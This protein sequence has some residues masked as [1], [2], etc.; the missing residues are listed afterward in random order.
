MT[1]GNPTAQR[2]DTQEQN[3]A[4]NPRSPRQIKAALAFLLAIYV[5]SVLCLQAFGFIFTTIGE[6][7]HAPA[8]GQLITAIPSLVLGI[9]CFVYGSLADY[10][11]LR[12]MTVA[13]IALLLAGSILGFALHSNIWLVIVARTLQTAGGQVAGS[14]YLVVAAKY[15]P[16]RDKVVFFGIFTAGYQLSTALGVLSAG[17]ISQIDWAYLFLLPLLAVF[18]LP[19]LL[20]DLPE[21]ENRHAH[22]DV[23]GFLLFGGAIGA[24]T[25]FFSY[26]RWWLLLVAAGLLVAFSVYIRHAARPFLTPRFLHNRRWIASI[27]VIVIIYF[28]NFSF[29]PVFNVLGPRLYGISAAQVSLVLLPGY[30]LAV[31]SGVCSGRV[32]R[33]IGEQRTIILGASSVVAGLLLEVLCVKAGLVPLAIGSGLFYGGLAMLYSP[34][35]S[36]VLGTLAPD[37]QGRGVGMNDLAMNVSPSTGTAIFGG[38]LAS[39]ALAGGSIIGA[40]GSAAIYSNLFLIYALICAAGLVYYLAVRKFISTE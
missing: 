9:V 28:V 30:I 25:L 2:P 18:L 37:E 33:A 15:L 19:A 17:F 13:G 5:L 3:L 4:K 1:S 23:P 27:L 16:E 40:T 22:V 39:P 12:K 10:V 32:V 34:I 6:D 14:V 35:T 29:T 11:S 8:Q 24:V 26:Y 36:T 7:L 31:V 38:L 21:G 20:R